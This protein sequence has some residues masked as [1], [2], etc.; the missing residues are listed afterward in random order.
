ML[1]RQT[2]VEKSACLVRRSNNTLQLVC[3]RYPTAQQGQSTDS[4]ERRRNKLEYTGI[5]IWRERSLGSN[6]HMDP[7]QGSLSPSCLLGWFS[8]GGVGLD[9]N[10]LHR[11]IDI[12][13]VVVVVEG[14]E[15]ARQQS[16]GRP[17]QMIMKLWSVSSRGM[18]QNGGG[19]PPPPRPAGPVA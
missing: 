15:A 5:S 6:E 13:V 3:H 18:S 19:A 7:R 8:S 4:T 11:R 9:C 17:F 16:G 14:C 10:L 2:H 1:D 12:G